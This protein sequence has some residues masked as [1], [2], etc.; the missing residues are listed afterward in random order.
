MVCRVD[1][2]I[3]VHV[4]TDNTLHVQI[5]VIYNEAWI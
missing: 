4:T 2:Y 5:N 3:G 1:L